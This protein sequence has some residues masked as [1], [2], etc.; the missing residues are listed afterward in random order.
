ML[1]ANPATGRHMLRRIE[2]QVHEQAPALLAIRVELELK[3]A[4]LEPRHNTEQVRLE[5]AREFREQPCSGEPAPQARGPAEQQELV[6]PRHPCGP[7][8]RR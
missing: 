6:E 2:E 3:G 7:P 5:Q 8:R 1:D 4:Q